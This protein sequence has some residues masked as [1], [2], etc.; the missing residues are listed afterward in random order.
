D[1]EQSLPDPFQNDLGGS[2]NL[3]TLVLI[4]LGQAPLLDPPAHL[5]FDLRSLPNPPKHLR[6]THNGTSKRLQEWLGYDARFRARRDTIQGDIEAAMTRSPA[7]EP[8]GYELRVGI[9]CQMGRHRSV[10]MVEGFSKMSWPGWQVR[11]EH[12]D[13]HKK[14]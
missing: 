9:N 5:A 11:V 7:A 8:S 4:S 3:P 12:R 1:N 2:E 10:A 13:I 6:D 14:R